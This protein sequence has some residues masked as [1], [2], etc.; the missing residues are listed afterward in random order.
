M[1]KRIFLCCFFVFWGCTIVQAQQKKPV[2]YQM[3]VRL[4]GNMDTT[5]QYYGSIIENGSGKFN[6]ITGKALDSLKALGATYIWYTGVLEHATMTDYSDYGI[7]MDDPDVVKGRAGSPYA[8]KDYY[9]VDP[10]LAVNVNHSME[11]FQALIDR[12]HR[13]GLKVLMDFIP[14]HV[15]RAYYSDAAPDSVISF[16]AQDDTAL[17][18][19]PKNDF[20]YLQGTVFQVPEGV[21][22]GG[23]DFHSPL[24]DGKFNEVPAKVTGNNV[25]RPDPSINDWYETI[26]LNYGVDIQ[27]DNREYFN[28]IPPVWEKMRDIL[29]YWT[30]KGVDGFRCDVAEMVP[31]EFWHWIIPQI[32]EINS[33]LIF[34]AEAYNPSDYEK[35]ISYGGFDYLYNKV[36]LYDVLRNLI[37]AKPGSNVQRIDSV[38][39]AQESFS[40][41]MLGFLENHDEQRIA[42]NQFAG[43]SWLAKPAMAVVATISRGPVLIYFGQELGEKGAGKEGFSGADGR[44]TIFDY[45]SVPTL[46]RWNNHG[47]FN[48]EKLTKSERRLRRFYQELLWISRDNNA[49]TNGSYKWIEN[50][51]LNAKQLAYFRLS[52]QEVILVIANFDRKETLDMKLYLPE[53]LQDRYHHAVNLLTERSYKIRNNKL[54]ISVSPSD[55]FILK[56]E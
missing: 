1:I 3:L 14:N 6:D 16:G 10:D 36:G 32:K 28:P 43:N 44:T 8:V 56:L 37:T 46:V 27:H 9:D 45:W 20:Y 33:K 21:N 25:F 13:H 42:S 51:H 4:F 50:E 29:V 40:G 39:Q 12:T 34:I 7:K 38:M 5:N 11:E 48:M 15:A 35:Y 55:A 52:S 2:I 31:V 30:Q 18:F 22:A 17:A 54:R 23:D 19:S 41:H 24:K 47:Q 26:K 49:I 53:G